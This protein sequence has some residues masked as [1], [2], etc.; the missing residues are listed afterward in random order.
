LVRVR[1]IGLR[2][3][4]GARLWTRICPRGCHGVSRLCSP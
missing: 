4:N 2:L 3:L 1:A